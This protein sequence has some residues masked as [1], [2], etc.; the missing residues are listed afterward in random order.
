MYSIYEFN[1]TFLCEE[2]DLTSSKQS[3]RMWN[4]I[5]LGNVNVYSKDIDW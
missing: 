2:D 5:V 1:M 3:I 4:E